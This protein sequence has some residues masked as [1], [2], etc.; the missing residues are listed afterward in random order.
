MINTVLV[1]E[2]TTVSTKGDVTAVDV[3]AAK[4]HVL[5]LTLDIT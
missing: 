4:C 2:K 5:L 3:R 1:P